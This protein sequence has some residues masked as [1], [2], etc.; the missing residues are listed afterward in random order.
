MKVQILLILLLG[1]PACNP[2]DDVREFLGLKKPEADLPQEM[3]A[4]MKSANGSD[5]VRG[6]NELAKENQ[7]LLAEMIRVSFDRDEAEDL[8]DFEALSRT[9]NQ[10]A[11]LEGIYRGI[12]MGSRYRALES[13]AQAASPTVLKVFATEM[14]ELQD[15]MRNPTHFDPKSAKEA[16]RIDYPEEGVPGA[17]PAALPSPSPESI[18]PQRVDKKEAFQNLIKIFIGASPYTLKRV[19]GEEAI[20]KFEESKDD[21]SEIPR[22]YADLAVRLAQTNV[23][24]GLE[25]RKKNDFQFHRRFA[26]KMAMDRVKWEVLNRY[27]RYLNSVGKND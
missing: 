24:F 17:T 3:K 13:N 18:L 25:L 10:G 15:S 26:Q 22:W 7:E 5:K 20:K 6:T 1:T 4:E 21:P 2:V 9:L 12:T 16:P 8:T 19:L 23:D 11:S 27:H 14:A